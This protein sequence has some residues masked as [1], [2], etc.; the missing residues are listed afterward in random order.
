M[1]T[2]AT[3][4]TAGTEVT[5]LTGNTYTILKVTRN[6]VWLTAPGLLFP[7]EVSPELVRV[8]LARKGK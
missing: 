7:Q 2:K 6:R 8:C 4:L 1:K 5:L 3:K